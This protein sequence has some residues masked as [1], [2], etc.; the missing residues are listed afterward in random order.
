M[1]FD[2]ELCCVQEAD[3]GKGAGIAKD[4][5]YDSLVAGGVNPSVAARAADTPL[6]GRAIVEGLYVYPDL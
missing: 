4:D 1:A 2:E 5:S 6:P 3:C